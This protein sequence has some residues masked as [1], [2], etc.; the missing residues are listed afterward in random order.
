VSAGLP[1]PAHHAIAAKKGKREQ[2]A[3]H[4]QRDR[5]HAMAIGQLDDDGLAA[6]GNGAD[7]GQRQP[8]ANFVE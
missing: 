4:H 8:G 7:D 5:V 1:R 2:H 3:V 6:E